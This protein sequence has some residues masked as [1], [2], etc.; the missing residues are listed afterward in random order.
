MGKEF[1][2]YDDRR[3]LV[4]VVEDEYVNRQ[5]LGHIMSEEYDVM[6]AQNGKEALEII[7]EHQEMLSLI[8]LDL[9]MPEMTGFELMEITL[10]MSVEMRLSPV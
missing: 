8:L 4:L 1:G 2:N 5:L 10:P 6:Y 3:R 7:R 9:M